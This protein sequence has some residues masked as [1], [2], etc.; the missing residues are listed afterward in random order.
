MRR[1]VTALLRGA[2]CRGGVGVSGVGGGE[3]GQWDGERGRR[4]LTCAD[5]ARAVVK[6]AP[7]APS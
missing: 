4:S 7:R 6:V 3:G 2:A 1:D 5:A